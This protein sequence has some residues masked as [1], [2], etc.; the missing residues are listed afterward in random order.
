[1]GR[2]L[3][4]VTLDNLARAP[5]EVLQTVYWE[6]EGDDP[7]VDARFQKE[8]WFS[9]TLLEWGPCGKLLVEGEETI[10]FAE[11]APPSLFPR[12]AA[13]DAGRPSADAVY[14][15]YCFV[16]PRHRGRGV[17]SELIRAVARDMLD[18]GYRAL[19]SLGEHVWTGGWLLPGGFLAAGGFRV[20]NDHPTTALWRLEPAEAARPHRTAAAAAARPNA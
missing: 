10:G 2:S 19:E 13:F 16:A 18:R 6:M 8:E 7:A 20:L 5:D 17:G 1:V 4:D 14:L 11:Y 15:A 9:A 12:V 3:L